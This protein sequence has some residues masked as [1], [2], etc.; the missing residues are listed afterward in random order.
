MG[1]LSFWK[2]GSI[3]GGVRVFVNDAY[4]GSLTHYFLNETPICAQD[5]TLTL[6]VVPGRAVAAAEASDGR[7]WSRVVVVRA[8]GCDL[9]RVPVSSVPNP[10]RSRRAGAVGDTLPRGFRAGRITR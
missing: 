1:R 5:G 8:G 6:S 3:A 9:V 2:D 4:A 7:R 10:E